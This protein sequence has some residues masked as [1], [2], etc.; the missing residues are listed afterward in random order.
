MLKLF[1]EIAIDNKYLHIWF[2]RVERFVDSYT[3]RRTGIMLA[4]VLAVSAL[5][6]IQLAV[7]PS[8]FPAHDE[9][10]TIPQ[11]ASFIDIARQ[12]E[13]Q[14]VVRSAEMLHVVSML[15]GT[16]DSII[17]GDY[18]F[19]KPVGLWTLW[20]R[21]TRGVFGLEVVAVRIPEGSTIITMADIFEQKMLR[22]NRDTFLG[23]AE[24]EEGFLFP[25][26]YHFLPN[27]PEQQLI[28]AMRDNFNTHWVKLEPD[29]ITAT[30]LSQ[31][32]I[33]TLASIVEL[34]AYKYQDRRKI[35]GVLYNRLAVDMAL[36]VDVSFVYLLGKGTYDLSRDDLQYDS[37][38][39]TYL[40][41]GLPPGPIGAPSLSSLKATIDP[42]ESD[43]FFY[44][45][46]RSGNTYFSEDYESH[47]QKKRVY[48]D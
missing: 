42:Y 8:G 43:W 2:A 28:A 31:H 37:P 41:K 9:L 32:E 6:Y 21:I 5:M 39:N 46:D 24:G 19:T 40:Y 23:L 34:E 7:P 47:L 4:V 17:A 15:S 14:H 30:G 3:T 29:A 33:V 26:T 20:R 48:V 12:L 18:L 45:A 16:T 36:Q 22:F 10:V 11:G 38:Y 25:D 35:A 13:E 1:E 44:L 27:T